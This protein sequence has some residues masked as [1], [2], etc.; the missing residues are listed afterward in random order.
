[1]TQ[2]FKGDLVESQIGEA[3]SPPFDSCSLALD[4]FFAG[5]YEATDF[6]LAQYD[7]GRMP[8]SDR[9]PRE[10]FVAF[11]KEALL[12]FETIGSFES[13]LFI[14]KAIFGA[15]SDIL[16]SIP[17]VAGQISMLVSASSSLEFD[18]QAREFV[19]GGAD[20]SDMTTM[21]GDGIQFRGVSGIDSEAKLKALLSEIIPGGLS[22]HITLGFF[23]LSSFASS[24]DELII[25]HLGNQIVFFET[26]A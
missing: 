10:T 8:F 16:F 11:F 20:F 26:G 12:N 4:E 2:S 3:G 17:T 21:D 14:V 6:L 15:Q 25:D 18:F 22:P 13:Y 24:A 1:M 5:G 7:A 23:T 19:D 9:V